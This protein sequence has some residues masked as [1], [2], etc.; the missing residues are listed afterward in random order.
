MSDEEAEHDDVNQQLEEIDE[1]ESEQV[2]HEEYRERSLEPSE[3]GYD[4]VK[5]I[6]F[7]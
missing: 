7:S 2:S 6:Y 1:Q 4:L 3:P 5:L